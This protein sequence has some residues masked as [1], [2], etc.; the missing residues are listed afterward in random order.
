MLGGVAGGTATY[1][2]V[3]PVVVRI[4]LVV[5]T[6]FGGLGIILYVIGWLLIPEDGKEVS[7]AQQALSDR[8]SGRHRWMTIVI[9]LV[10]VFA[11]FGL[12]SN[13]QRWWGPGWFLGFGV[14]WVAL[15]AVLVLVVTRVGGARR[16]GRAHSRGRGGIVN[17]AQPLRPRSSVTIGWP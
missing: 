6:L 3:D 5:L 4:A 16:V 13:G 12:L 1:L 9:A 8:G 2:G 15:A 11:F 10:A 17:G 7:L 14:I